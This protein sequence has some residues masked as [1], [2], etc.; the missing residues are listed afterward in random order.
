[1]NAYRC[2]FTA[3][4]AS[5]GEVAARLSAPP[6]TAVRPSLRSV[7]RL[8]EAD[9]LQVMQILLWASPEPAGAMVVKRLERDLVARFGQ[10]DVRRDPEG[11]KPDAVIVALRG[12]DLLR[13]QSALETT[14]RR[15]HDRAAPLFVLPLEPKALVASAKLAATLRPLAD[16]PVVTPDE[17]LPVLQYIVEAN[18]QPT[19][20]LSAPSPT[21]YRR[22][23]R[24]SLVWRLRDNLA[25]RDQVLLKIS[26]SSLMAGL[27]I[28]TTLSAGGASL[29]FFVGAVTFLLSAPP[30]PSSRHPNAL[31]SSHRRRGDDDRPRNGQLP[32]VNGTRRG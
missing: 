9:T 30:E 24:P 17:V 14:V 26:G 18:Q 20:S 29:F 16:A 6:L 1:M 15:A 13:H 4:S 28:L 31:G 25:R 11:S 22:S 19:R 27:L 32:P 2:G 5:C 10:D 21:V 12:Q 23:S 8:P 7:C 3:W